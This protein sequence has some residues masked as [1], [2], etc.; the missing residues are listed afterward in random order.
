M[1][2]T[3]DRD[4]FT[5]EGWHTVAPRIVVHEAKQLAEFVK[6]VFRRLGSIVQTHHPS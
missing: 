6:Y 5:P 2:E 3:R 1:N 4:H